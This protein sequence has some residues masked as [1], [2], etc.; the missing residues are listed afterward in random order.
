MSI[1]QLESWLA[2]LLLSEILDPFYVRVL[3]FFMKYWEYLHILQF[4]Q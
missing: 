3:F 2:T 1:G 4:L